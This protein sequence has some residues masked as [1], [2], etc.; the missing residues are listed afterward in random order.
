MAGRPHTA[1]FQRPPPR[2]RLA[3]PCFGLVLFRSRNRVLE[4][5]F[6]RQI[7]DLPTA[8]TRLDAAWLALGR[9]CLKMFGRP[10]RPKTLG[11]GCWN[12]PGRARR[13]AFQR[14]PSVKTHPR[15]GSSPA[16]RAV[17]PWG[18]P[19]AVGM[20]AS[21][22]KGRRG[23]LGPKGLWGIWGL[24]RSYFEWFMVQMT[25]CMLRLG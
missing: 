18:G 10:G 8:P 15:I 22:A 19:A 14:H 17:L 11:R 20:R 7:D 2:T 6:W 9:C 25:R 5:P 4:R 1:S 23:H 16:T 12:R 3:K 24:F 13:A 21:W